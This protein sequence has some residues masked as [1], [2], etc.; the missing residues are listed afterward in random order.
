MAKK[1]EDSIVTACEEARFTPKCQIIGNFPGEHGVLKVSDIFGENPVA[2]DDNS[3]A[4]EDSVEV[5]YEEPERNMFK[6][7]QTAK[8]SRVSFAKAAAAAAASTMNIPTPKTRFSN[9]GLDEKFDLKPSAYKKAKTGR[10]KVD[11]NETGD[12]G[13]P[14]AAMRPSAAM[15]SSFGNF[16][17]LDYQDY[18]GDD[19]YE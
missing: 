14:L 19:N 6:K 18:H 2:R 8:A 9:A 13:S 17:P 11:P 5:V 4:S 7:T 10:F 15:R 12:G 16:S 1:A 3:S